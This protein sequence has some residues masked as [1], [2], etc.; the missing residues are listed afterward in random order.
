M[1]FGTST[2]N[3]DVEYLKQKGIKLYSV[4][5]IKTIESV[6]KLC[7]TFAL[8]YIFNIQ[9]HIYDSSEGKWNRY[10][11]LDPKNVYIGLIGAGEIATSFYKYASPLGFN[12]FYHSRNENEYFKN[13]EVEYFSDI[14]E[15]IEAS[16]NLSLHIPY[17]NETM[18]LISSEELSM[19]NNKLLINTSRAG[20]VSK[21]A[22]INSLQELQNFHY[23][24]D[25]LYT[26][27][28]K[29]EDLK[30]ISNKNVF[31][32]A[33]IGG[34]SESALIDVANKSLSIINSEL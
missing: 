1:R 33:H 30:I 3:I 17:N 12:F 18:D 16:E 9:K 4:K 20:I 15:I 28:P 32:T 25:V 34:Y 27:P 10:I 5:S 19:F 21:K 2:E 26:E 24:T 31:S 29:K 23:F 11:N 6:S 13:N 22:L 8:S 14:K 7:T